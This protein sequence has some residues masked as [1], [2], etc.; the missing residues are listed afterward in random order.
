MM[1]TVPSRHQRGGTPGPVSFHTNYSPLLS[2][3]RRRPDATQLETWPCPT[4]F[5]M[6]CWHHILSLII[7]LH[8]DDNSPRFMFQHLKCFCAILLVSM[9]SKSLHNVCIYILCSVFFLGDVWDVV[10]RCWECNHKPFHYNSFLQIHAVPV[11]ILHDEDTWI[12][13]K[14]YT[15][16]DYKSMCSVRRCSLL[17][18]Q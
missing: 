15:G 7:I 13:L 8:I 18:S 4:T 6:C 9:T 16:A 1:D 2:V 17:S 10:L 3:V 5:E 14:F 12:S 11:N